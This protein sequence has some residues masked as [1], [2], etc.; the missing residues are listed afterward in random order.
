MKKSTFFDYKTIKISRRRNAF[1]ISFYTKISINNHIS[2]IPIMLKPFI[3]LSF[4][5]CGVCFCSEPKSRDGLVRCMCNYFVLIL[6]NSCSKILNSSCF[7]LLPI[8]VSCN[9]NAMIPDSLHFS[10][11]RSFI[12]L[13]VT[14]SALL[15]IP[16]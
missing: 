2:I 6:N 8:V 11:C 3:S 10:F 16:P 5:Y 12:T 14:N 7:L 13:S 9:E 1:F 15:P 4:L